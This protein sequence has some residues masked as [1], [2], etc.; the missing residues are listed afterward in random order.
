M[1]AGPGQIIG[2]TENAV[3][4]GPYIADVNSNNELLTSADITTYNIDSTT[5]TLITITSQESNVREGARFKVNDP[6]TLGDNDIREWL[7]ITQDSD[8]W[9][10]VNF[11]ID[12]DLAGKAQLFENTNSSG[13]T[14]L[15][16][17]NRNRNSSNI[18]SLTVTHTPTIISDG[19]PGPD[20][21]FGG[22]KFISTN[23]IETISPVILKRNTKYL[24]RITSEAAANRINIIMWST[25]FANL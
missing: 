1:P 13:G 5:G 2:E 9:A 11:N 22:G 3:T 12:G 7:I 16:I 23:S 6:V 19:T 24:L 8:T 15:V 20:E 25:E 4:G 18:S 10:H 21:F 14:P 17:S